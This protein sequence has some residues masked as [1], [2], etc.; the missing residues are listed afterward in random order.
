[1]KT[2]LLILLL[3]FVNSTAPA[4][5][6][7]EKSFNRERTFDVLHYSMKLRFDRVKKSVF[8][9]T[10]VKLQ[11]LDGEIKFVELD[12][13]DIAFDA[14]TSVET[15]KK[16]GFKYDKKTIR[17]ELEQTLQ[18]G[19]AVSIRL[20]YKTTPSKGI[21]FVNAARSKGK[22]VRSAQIWTQ[23]EA[24]EARHWLPSYDFP[25]DKAT[26]EQEITVM[27]TE[28]VIGNGQL[29]SNILNKDGSRTFR[30]RMDIPHSVYLTSFVVGKFSAN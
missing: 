6:E 7:I 21:Y 16:L 4:A 19:S 20:V 22:I 5:E 17:I 9:D 2:L 3:L 12:A 15:G 11:P 26:T 13:V 25:D 1:M 29:V 24:E 18:P 14:V 27:G 23:G 10:T 28:T 8:G 30:F